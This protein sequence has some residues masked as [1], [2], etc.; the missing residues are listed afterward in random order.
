MAMETPWPRQKAWSLSQKGCLWCWTAPIRLFTQI[1]SFSGMCNISM[2]PLG[3]SWR[4]SQTTRGPSTKGSTPLSIRAAAPSICRSPQRSCQTLPCTTVLWVTQWG[5][6]QGKLHMNQGCRR[7]QGEAL[8]GR[9]CAFIKAVLPL[10][11]ENTNKPQ[12][13]FLQMKVFVV[14]LTG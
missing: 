13:K 7:A 10:L 6:L 11:P 9:L 2:N 1:L 12:I 5:R 4:A 14:V 3:Y 8:R